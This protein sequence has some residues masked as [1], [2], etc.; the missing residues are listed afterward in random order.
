MRRA[1]VA[2]ILLASGTAL[3]EPRRL[4]VDDVVRIALSGHPRF[5]AAR[6]NVEAAQETERSTR[7]RLFPSVHLSEDAQH[8]DSPFALPFGG[9]SFTAR[10]QNT[11]TF[12]ASANQ[13]ILGLLKLVEAYRADRSSAEAAEAGLKAAE[14]RAR[15]ALQIEYLR[16][17]EAK[18]M[19]Q[20][21]HASEHQLGEEVTMTEAKVKAGS[22]TNADLL[23]VQ[24][25]RENARHRAI[26]A[27]TDAVTARAALLSAIGVDPEDETVD[28]TEP[29]S[30]LRAPEKK[31]SAADARSMA[32]ER[33]PEIAEGQLLSEAASH[34]AQA[35][36]WAMLPDVNVEAAYMRVDGQVFAPPNSAYVGVSARWPVW[37]WGATYHAGEAAK[38]RARA[39]ES[40]LENERREVVQE[41][42]TRRA[43]LDAAGSAVALAEHII[44]SAEE[45]YRVTQALV[46]AGAATTT[47]LLQAE[48]TLTE[49]RLNHTRDVYAEAIAKV[50]LDRVT[51]TP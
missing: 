48:A 20:I 11:N 12:V 30:L 5:A 51:G 4:T 23:R 14:L 41:V 35:A 21:A 37:E 24:V 36:K 33:R 31:P 8:Y 18:A 32:L 43:Q 6:S 15:E 3:A 44:A 45:A 38:A 39:A 19:E 28:F 25:A 10:D 46:R 34:R 47:D 22:S 29:A 49:A 13:P 9:Q 17:F 16:L 50:S 42:T 40:D 26:V 27:N 7:G 1:L 2:A